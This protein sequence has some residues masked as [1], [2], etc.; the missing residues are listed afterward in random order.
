MPDLSEQLSAILQN[1]EA[2]RNIRNMLSSLQNSTEQKPPPENPPFDFSAL[3]GSAPAPPKSEEPFPNMD[4]G[5]LMKIQ[6][7][8]SKMSCDDHNVN[9]LKALR[10]HLQKPEKVDDAINILRLMSVLPALGEA[11]LFGGSFR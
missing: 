10:P 1:P 7:I 8:F 2:Q 9:L 3:F 11:G 5:M 4:I 6:S